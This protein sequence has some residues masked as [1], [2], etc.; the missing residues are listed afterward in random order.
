MT[1]VSEASAPAQTRRVSIGER[2]GGLRQWILL[3]PGLGW[4]VAFFVVPLC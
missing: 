3:A 1:A 2:F 4:L